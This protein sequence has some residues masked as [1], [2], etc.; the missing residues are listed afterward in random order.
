MALSIPAGARIGVI[1]PNGSGKTTLFNA[2]SGLVALAAGVVRLDGEEISRLPPHQIAGAGVARTF[3]T[4]RLFQRL[5]VLDN[6]L[7]RVGAGALTAAAARRT[8][9]DALDAVGLAARCETI[10]GDLTFFEQR[11]LEIARALAQR[12]RVLLIDEPTSGLSHAEA[13]EVINLLCRGTDPSTALLVIEHNIGVLERLCPRSILLVEGR[14]AAEAAT[15][16]MIEDRTFAGVY[17]GTQS[18]MNRD[19]SFRQS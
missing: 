8:A 17:F 2:I 18:V 12:P 3:Q 5:S 9:L 6:A 4:V 1:G 15:R 16:D 7:P 10:A 19:E 14:L 13:S 11:R